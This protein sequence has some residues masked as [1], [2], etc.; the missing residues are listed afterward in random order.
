MAERAQAEAERILRDH[1]VP[2]LEQAQEKE[3]DRL[4]LAAEQELTAQ[5]SR[6]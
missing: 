1:Q 4:M 2:P 6:R 5:L 3:L